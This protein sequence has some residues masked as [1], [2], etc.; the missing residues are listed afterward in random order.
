MEL[1]VL[2]GIQGA[3]K[4]TFC[5][6]RFWETH[7]RLSLDLLKSRSREDILLFACFAA[8]QRVVVDNT[9]PTAKQRTRYARLGQAAGFRTV[10]YFFDVP[11]AE[12]LAR[13]AG[14]PEVQRV[15]DLGVRG[16]FAKLQTPTEAEGFDERYVVRIAACG[17][18]VERTA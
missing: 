3:G 2:S 9:S 15:P 18:N 13:N 12:A 5:R 6:Q 10:L 1:V 16:T 7:V 14:R 4:S 8:Q 17:F 11:V